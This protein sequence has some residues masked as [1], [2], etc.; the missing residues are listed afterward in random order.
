MMPLYEYVCP[1]CG[2]QTDV[3][4]SRLEH[5]QKARVACAGCGHR[6][7]RRIVSAVS[8]RR[9]GA[10]SSPPPEH[11]ADSTVD[12]TPQGLA[13]TMRRSAR[14]RDMGQEFSEVAAR[15][16]KGE[17]ASAI[18]ASLRKRKRQKPGPH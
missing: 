6:R 12:E 2:A 10:A 9:G 3:L 5:A 17:G 4:Y 16:E 18:E 15:L 11:G 14:G 7:M 1:R 13:R 8:V